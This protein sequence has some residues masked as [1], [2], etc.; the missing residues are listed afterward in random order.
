MLVGGVSRERVDDVHVTGLPG[1]KVH[2]APD[3]RLV[4]HSAHVLQVQR[5]GSEYASD[6]VV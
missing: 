6:V 2:W 3:A 4:D 5:V 1:R